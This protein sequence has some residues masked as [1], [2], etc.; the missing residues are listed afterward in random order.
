[1]IIKCVEIRDRLTCI[2]AIAIKMEAADL[3]EDRFLWRCGYP[4]DGS[5][6]VLMKLSDQDASS[7]PYGRRWG[8]TRTMP[9]ALNWIIDHFDDVKHGGVVDV[10]VILGEATEPAV[11]EILRHAGESP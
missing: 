4:R 11:T 7:D 1:M 5:S 3:I 6:V 8:G 9:A 10:R 2:P